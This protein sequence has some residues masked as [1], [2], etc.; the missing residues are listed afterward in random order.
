MGSRRRA[1]SVGSSELG[2]HP[3]YRPSFISIWSLAGRVPL[4]NGRVLTLEGHANRFKCFFCKAG[5]IQGVGGE[6]EEQG[7]GAEYVSDLLR[8]PKP[9]GPVLEHPYNIERVSTVFQ[10]SGEGS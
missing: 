1:G 4:R 7:G 9:Y 6:L 8:L 5:T 10:R 3:L 2:E